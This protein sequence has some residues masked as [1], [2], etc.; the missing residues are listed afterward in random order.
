M[1]IREQ[2]TSDFIEA[3]SSSAPV[4]GGGGASAYAG[5]LGEALSHMVG[6]L[7]VGKKKYQA[8]ESE[9]REMME[10]AKELEERFLTLVEKDADAFAP[11]AE[12]YRLPKETEEERRHK[13]EVMEKCLRDAA[14]APLLIMEACCEGIALAEDFA[15][16]GSTLAISDAGVSASLLRAALTGASLNVFINTGAMKDSETAAELEKKANEMLETY[17]P[18]ADV[19]FDI[20]MQ[21]LR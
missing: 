7:T 13:E 18:R 19:V 8:V 16:K 15:E 20:V 11:L 1:N 14:E 9:I 4:P 17:V 5:A 21:R 6:S 2:T 10:K 3:L 12:A